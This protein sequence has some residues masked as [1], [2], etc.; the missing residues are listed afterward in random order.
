MTLAK[1]YCINVLTI[2]MKWNVFKLICGWDKSPFKSFSLLFMQY[3]LGKCLGSECNVGG[4]R[5]TL[6][7]YANDILN[8]SFSVIVLQHIINSL[9]SYCNRWNLSV[10][11]NKSKIMVIKKGGKLRTKEGSGIRVFKHMVFQTYG[12]K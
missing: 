4:N 3:D 11:L 9:E 5:V 8:F 12:L 2:E 7:L 6:L 1:H 10:N